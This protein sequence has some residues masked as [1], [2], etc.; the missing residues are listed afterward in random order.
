MARMIAKTKTGI[1]RKGT[2][3]TDRS[4]LF[5]V[6]LYDTYVY[7]EEGETLTL[8][9]GGWNTPT[10]A[11]RINSALM[12]RGFEPGISTAG[13]VMSFFGKPFIN[14]VLV[15]KVSELKRLNQEVA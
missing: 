14:G 9:N 6:K 13:G 5:E 10:T 4:G 7:S 11:Q 2:V 12:Y 1:G 8:Q 3:I 15:L